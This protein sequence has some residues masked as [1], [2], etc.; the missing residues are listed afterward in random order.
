MFQFPRFPP[1]PYRERVA[2]REWRVSVACYS[3][4][5]T[6]YLLSWVRVPGHDPGRVAPFGN[7]RIE[8]RWR[9]PVA[10]RNQLRPSS[11]PSAKAFSVRP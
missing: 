8:A 7:P 10:Y 2:S 1:A 6:C 11:A 5:A 3:L 9:L 4:L